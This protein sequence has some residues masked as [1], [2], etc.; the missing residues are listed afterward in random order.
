MGAE[1]RAWEI[2][3]ALARVAHLA[4]DG[5]LPDYLDMFTEDALWETPAVEATAIKA[6]RRRGRADI[7]EGASARRA[8]GIQGP[9]SATRHVVHTIEVTTVSEDTATSVS[10]WAFYQSTTATPALAGMGRYDD[11]WRL[12]GTGW[13]LA[14]RRI[15][16]G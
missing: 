16:L 5:E 9:G 4:D 13:K 10:Y 6:D 14:H 3:H 15:T 2:H 7:G 12:T 11:T 1:S 8:S